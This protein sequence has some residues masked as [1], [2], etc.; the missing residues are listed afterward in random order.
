MTTTKCSQYL[1][2]LSPIFSF[3]YVIIIAVRRSL[4]KLV[5]L[6]EQPLRKIHT[7]LWTRINSNYFEM[8]TISPIYKSQLLKKNV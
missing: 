7:A 2:W 5:I 8:M 3:F 1:F 4:Y 6:K